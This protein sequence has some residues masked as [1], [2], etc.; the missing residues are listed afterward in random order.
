LVLTFHIRFW[1]A[2]TF[3]LKDLLPPTRLKLGSSLG[4]G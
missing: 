3:S 4:C 1:N 2:D